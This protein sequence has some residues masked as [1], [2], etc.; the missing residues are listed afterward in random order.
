[1]TMS[2]RPPNS[3]RIA[4]N[5]L[6]LYLRMLIVTIVGLY[7]SRVVLKALGV[8]DFGLHSVIGGV[9]SLFSFF[10]SSMEKC[11][12]RFLNFEMTKP[13]GR[14]HDTFGNALIIHIGLCLI[15]LMLTESIGIWFLNTYIN[16][17]AGREFAANCVYQTVIGGLLLTI[18]TIPFSACIIANER[19]GVFALISIVDCVLNLGIVYI[20]SISSSD[21]LIFYSV[22]LLGIKIFNFLFYVLYCRW[23]FSEANGKIS[24]DKSLCRKML[25]YT[26]WTLLG[27]AMILGTNQGNSILVN[28]FH[29]VGANA[30][31][32]IANHVNSHV[33]NLTNNFQTAF[34]PQITKSYAS[35]NYPYLRS[36]I[37]S[38]SKISYFLLFSIALPLFINID[39]V[40]G[41]WLETVP[42]EADIF[43]V[44]ILS[45]GILQATTS[46]LNFSIMA[47]GNIKWY[48]ITTGFVFISDLFILYALFSLGLPAPTA[49][50]V[51][52]L[53]MCFVT[54]VRL[55]FAHRLIKEIEISDYLKRA[56]V[57]IILTTAICLA[58]ALSLLSLTSTTPER[59]F[60]TVF[61][62]AFSCVAIAFLGLTKQ[63]RQ[64][65]ISILHKRKKL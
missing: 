9:V 8:E 12:Q 13:K 57:P 16:I 53:I 33:L 23:K 37:F 2:N 18:L 47:T 43:C 19:M 44:L 31:M 36:L 48:Q 4:K 58:I 49:M 39:F 63:E 28:M 52:I 46:P 17:P 7:T 26:S 10:R 62:F 51:K 29:G 65:I 41:V 35:G 34:N 11:T 20:I 54:I 60:A 32:A 6:L 1:M 55:Y 45:S 21:R 61:I 5:T 42:P 30:A 56:F 22:L 15:A 40:L 64:M 14:L 27:H 25:G 50:W 24:Y 3:R 59:L 38:T